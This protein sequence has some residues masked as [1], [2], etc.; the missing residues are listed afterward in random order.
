MVW[1]S[2]TAQLFQEKEMDIV[3][4]SIK[5]PPVDRPIMYT[6]MT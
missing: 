1:P 5:F 6:Y 4:H 2:A 3:C